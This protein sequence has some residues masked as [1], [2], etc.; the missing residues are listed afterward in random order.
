MYMINGWGNKGILDV[1]WKI[2]NY[3]IPICLD[4]CISV[5]GNQPLASS[6]I[7]CVTVDSDFGDTQ[8]VVR[9]NW[10]RIARLGVAHVR[11]TCDFVHLSRSSATFTRR[12]GTRNS[13]V[14]SSAEAIN[15]ARSPT[16]AQPA[17]N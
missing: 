2:W 9:S 10:A 14:L 12:N 1:N 13:C 3:T 6:D 15:L 8:R 11:F 7:V 16:P 17:V 5:Q 4:P